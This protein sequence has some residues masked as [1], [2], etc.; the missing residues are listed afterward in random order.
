[1]AERNLAQGDRDACSRE[2]DLATTFSRRVALPLYYAAQRTQRGQHAL[3]ADANGFFAVPLR[4]DRFFRDH[5]LAA[6]ARLDEA[7]ERPRRGARN[8]LDTGRHIRPADL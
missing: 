3:G 6:R 2:P 4:P 8:P 7:T 1:M 5:Q